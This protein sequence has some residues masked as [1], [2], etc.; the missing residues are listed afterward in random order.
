MKFKLLLI[1]SFLF[2]LQIIAGC[3]GNHSAALTDS[4]SS[5]NQ[6]KSA[7]INSESSHAGQTAQDF[8]QSHNQVVQNKVAL[9]QI[10]YNDAEKTQKLIRAYN[11]NRELAQQ[12]YN[13]LQKIIKNQNTGEITIFF[14]VNKAAIPENSTEYDRLVRFIDHIEG[15]STGRKIVFVL[16][17]SAS[18][19]GTEG[20]NKELARERANAPVSIIDHY[21]VN[22]PHSF[23]KIYGTGDMYS[24]GNAAENINK[25]YQHVR[26]M[27]MYNNEYNRA[28]E[29]RMTPKT[30][31]NSNEFINSIGMKFIHVHSGSFIM[32]SPKNELRR[33]IF[34]RLHKVTLTKGFYFQSTEVTQQQWLDVMGSNPSHFL[35]CGMDCPVENIRWTDAVKFIKKLN[36]KERTERY[37]LPTEAEWEYACRAGTATAF[38]SGTMIQKGDYSNNHF[39]DYVGW[40]YRNSNES[41]HKTALKQPNAWGFY[42]M[43]G[44]VWEWCNDWQRPYPF[45]PVT[46]PVGASS[47]HTKIR[48]GGSWCHYPEYCR[49]AYRSFYD[50]EDRSP[51]LGFRLAFSEKE[52]LRTK[53]SAPPLPEPEPAPK[54][55]PDPEPVPMPKPDP[56]PVPMPKPAKIQQC[57]VIRDITFD[58]DSSKLREEMKPVLNRAVEILQNYDGQIDLFGN[59][60]SKGSQSYNKNLAFERAKTVRAY[61]IS[62][63]I[64]AKRISVTTFGEIQPKYSNLTKV[65]RLLNRRVEIRVYGI[66]DLS[67]L[68][69]KQ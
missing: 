10:P 49:S 28:S 16:I 42:D 57:I 58:F 12:N 54:P 7:A 36:K 27:A 8:V 52:P 46:D 40:Y 44:N 39:L 38:Y 11:K 31:R 6:S 37:R 26:I 2:T 34:E 59:T 60:C 61:F 33:E 56:E 5:Y 48:R 19:I 66:S 51:E 50:P 23:Y 32:G 53:L 25:R 69:D 41:T 3:T 62:K 18:K 17:G 4:N 68:S 13:L 24:P 20:H 15:N 35:N 63:Q 14:T 65:G 29:N 1:L 30:E 47:A 67:D 22:I 64:A 45:N 21:L 9:T 43:H 55:K